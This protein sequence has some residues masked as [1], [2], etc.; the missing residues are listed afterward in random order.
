MKKSI[1]LLAIMA[2]ASQAEAQR[3]STAQARQAA[4]HYLTFEEPGLA[5]DSLTLQA[6]LTNTAGDTLLYA[7]NIGQ[8][9]YILT[10]TD[11]QDEPIVG[12]C[13][14]TPYSEATLPPNLRGFLQGY[15]QDLQAVH[16]TK[17][18]PADIVQ[19]R[20][21][22]AQEWKALLAGDA[23]YYASKDAKSVSPLIAT[24][25]SQGAGYNNYCP[26][27]S[28]GD[29]GH[30][31]TGCVAT[32]MA[33]IIRYHCYPD[34]GFYHSSYNHSYFGTQSA[35][36][37]S[38]YYDYSLMPSGVSPYSPQNQ[39]QAVSL[40]CYHCGVSVKMNYE[41]PNHTSGSGAQSNDV[42][43]GLRYF[44]YTN[45]HYLVK[46]SGTNAIWDSLL[47]HDLD[48]GRPVYYSGSSSDYGHAFICDGYNNSGKYHFNFGWGYGND[49][50]FTLTS[51]NGFSSN[52]AMVYNIVPSRLAPYHGRYYMSPDTLGGGTSWANPTANLEAAISIC[53]LYREGELWVS[54]G[55]Y[56]G[57]TTAATA[58]TMPQNISIY[59]GFTGGENSLS[60]RQPDAAP[61]IMS[62]QNR[63][64]VL[65]AS[66]LAKASYIY[67]MTFA[68]GYAANGA[69]INMERNL[70]LERCTIRN[71][72]ATSGAAI[73][74]QNC[75]ILCCKIYNNNGSAVAL[76]DGTVKSSLIAHNSGHGVQG[77]NGSLIEGCNIVC[78]S[79]VGIINT[80]NP[81]IHN[82][83]VWHND[84]SLT[85][86]D[87]SKITFCAIEGLAIE[88]DSNSNFGL[89]ADNWPTDGNGPRFKAP[90]TTQ[91]P[92]DVLGDWHLAYHS[93]LIDA[94]DT[95]RSG[96]HTYDLDSDYRIRNK[97]IDIGCYEYNKSV[98]IQTAETGAVL[99]LWPNPATDR[100]T[101]E[102]QNGNSQDISIYN[103][104]GRLLMHTTLH[105]GRATLDL[106]S[107][108]AGLYILRC[109]PTTT[110]FVKQ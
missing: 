53:G 65:T 6:V 7:F 109:G 64:A 88:L 97:R 103:V 99:Q 62:G 69:A 86:P 16:T 63:R 77:N 94:G 23:N 19:C 48:R 11:K 73:N 67:D 24:H 49:G 71:N 41:N 70:T 21:K 107:L 54:S 108:P 79:G 80:D 96:P 57:D 82:T 66:G 26:S 74:N 5:A 17:A 81:R 58:F 15:M 18:L 42:P 39:Q 55:T 38:T 43:A 76:S 3:I 59:G 91:G 52:Q 90:D 83:V 25:W 68:D 22:A 47:H 20:Y 4:S 50:Y 14:G 104:M 32:A 101:I 28:A 61:A 72:T 93:P 87:A 35:Q 34:T 2:L 84:S 36:Y 40:L 75:H 98:S 85:N 102:L 9:G 110:K 44:G 30:S 106:Q 1:L 56:I 31:V 60:D 8:N 12:Y 89:H 95:I 78:N 100:L 29:G 27:Y 10:G 51:V 45:C 13:L 33:Q 46:G 105:S 92:S 37:D